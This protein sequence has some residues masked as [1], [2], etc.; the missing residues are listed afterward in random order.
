MTTRK[1]K[2]APKR[3]SK[4]T[5]PKTKKPSREVSGPSRAR[6][7][8]P[9][10][11]KRDFAELDGAEVASMDELLGS[12]V[13]RLEEDA[14][15]PHP[16]RPSVYSEA[17]GKRICAMVAEGV[18]IAVAC[19]IEGVGKS[20]L[21]EWRARGAAGDEPFAGFC[22]EL[23]R[24]RDICEATITSRL[25]RAS[26]FDWKAGA[27]WLERRRPQRYQAKQD[28]TLHKSPAEMSDAELAAMMAEFGYAKA[29]ADGGGSDDSG[30]PTAQGGE[31]R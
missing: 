6:S 24:A 26:L 28:I 27:W 14:P 22:A 4:V 11:R 12:S 16:G 23:E 20:T 13:P 18:P 29:A 3:A 19:R 15:E 7:T 30:E 25:V 10:V 1:R 2:S 17:R 9:R 31:Q 5:K 8:R 21:Y